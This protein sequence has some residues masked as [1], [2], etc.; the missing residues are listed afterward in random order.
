MEYDLVITSCVTRTSA[1]ATPDI[2]Q[3]KIVAGK[4]KKNEQFLPAPTPRFFT[5][6]RKGRV[7]H[8]QC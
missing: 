1:D 5:N 2:F 7:S 4:R 6:F 8:E 3:K